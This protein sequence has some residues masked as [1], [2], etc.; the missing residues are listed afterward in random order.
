M[1][2]TEGESKA[3]VASSLLVLLSV[4]SR[5]LLQAPA[6]D[7]RSEGIG[8]AGDVDSALIAAESALAQSERRRAPLSRGERIDPNLAS[9]E[10]LDRLPG[11]GPA[12][13][14]A[15]ALDRR[16]QGPFLTLGDLERVPGLGSSTVDRL[17][18]FVTLP[19]S[20][21]TRAG[22]DGA[23]S[24][25]GRTSSAR[26]DLNRASQAELEALPGIGPARASAIVRWR[27]EH[28][29][30]RDLEDLL[31]VPGIGS[32]TLERLRSLVTVGP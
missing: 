20:L 18:A 30:F 29:L 28:G 15:I 4:L 9:E 25:G 19:R 24:K 21:G 16:R 13:A 7:V 8:A 12:L 23:D 3:L 1:A 27:D 5:T 26:L 6:A 14:R 22:R 11:I 10:E 31:Q 32:G 2:L 17:A